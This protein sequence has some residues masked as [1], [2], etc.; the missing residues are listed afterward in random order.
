[1]Y[2]CYDVSCP[3]YEENNPYYCM[4]CSPKKHVHLSFQIANEVDE[5][6]SKWTTLKQNI[7]TNLGTVTISY[8]E[9]KPL[10][11]YLE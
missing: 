9:L 5:L 2:V 10:I 11:L 1:M 3:N 8:K 4:K 7:Q 6:H